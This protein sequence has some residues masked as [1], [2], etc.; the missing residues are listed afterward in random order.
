MSLRHAVA[1]LGLI[2][3][4]SL[5]ASGS[6]AQSVGTDSR[7]A[8]FEAV[9]GLCAVGFEGAM[10]FPDDPEH[11]FAG[12]LLVAQI[13]ECSPSEIRIPFAVGEDRSRTWILS[14]G[15][16]GLLLKHDHRHAD[17]TPDEITMY[18]GWATE[19][20]T[21]LTQSFPADEATAEL[22]PAAATNVWTL[23][24]AADGSS[25]TYSLERHGE[26]RFAATLRRR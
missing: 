9:A 26:P 14:L 7:A 18:G 25:L 19:G 5:V 13:A 23:A 15:E 12:K 16:A 21:A 2:F 22:I 10:S 1:A 6:S 11:A 3:G 24:L 17:G 8:F 4:V 20:G